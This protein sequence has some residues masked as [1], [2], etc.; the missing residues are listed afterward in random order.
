[1]QILHLDASILGEASVSRTLS[2]QIV[3]RLAALH[4]DSKVIYRDLGQDPALHLSLEHLSAWQGTVAKDPMLVNDLFKGNSYLQELLDSQIVVIGA[5][6]Y[7]LTIPS[8]LKSWI[9]RVAISGKSFQYTATGPEGLLKGKQ[10]Y[11]ASSRGGVYSPGSPAAAL[12]HQESYLIG[13]LGFL[14]V[15]DTRV[16]RAEGLAVSPEAKD[17]AINRA[18]QEIATIGA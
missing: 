3:A 17:E 5:P 8:T 6:M 4:P 7:N 12:E 13:L 18:L 15:T 10:A 14:G 16:V 2:S 9:D 1:M 11:I